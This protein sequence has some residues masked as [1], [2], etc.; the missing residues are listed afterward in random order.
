VFARQPVLTGVAVLTLSLGIGANAAMYSVLNAVLF[1]PLPFADAD[2]TVLVVERVRSGGGTS[3]TIPEI[4]D[5]RARSR[6]LDVV[7]FFDTRDAQIEGGAEPAHVS[8][9]RVDPAFLP[10]VGAR[11]AL[12]RL[13]TAEDSEA[14]SPRV[15]LLSDGLWRRNFGA[16][17]DVVGRTVLVN[18]ASHLIAGVL[19]PEFT[20][21]FLSGEPELYLPY[22]LVP[23]YTQRSGEFANVRRVETIGRVKPGVSLAAAS[24]DLASVS[25]GLVAEHP[26]LYANFG[27][28][29][30]FVIDVQPLREAVGEGGRRGLL[31]LF[32][33]V[34]LVLLIA[35]VNAAQFL[36]SHAIEREPEVALRNALGAGRARLV[37]QFLSETLLLAVAAG[38][39]GVAQ[40]LWLVRILRSQ[41]P[42]MLMVGR[43]DLDVRVL[44]FVAALAIGTT[45]V[46]GL[47]PSLRFSR[48]RL[49]PGLEARASTSP[50]SRARQVLIAIEVG[51]SVV[52]LVQAALLIRTLDVLQKSQAGFSSESVL[53]MRMRG[54]S[55]GGPSTGILYAQYL[56]RM[57]VV[58]DIAHAAIASSVLPGGAGTPYAIV[59]RS[60]TEAARSRQRTS[61][62]I[63]SPDYFAVLNIPFRQGR[64]FSP[65]ETA[66][67]MPVAVINEEMARLSWP[68]EDP[69]GQRLRA[70]E[71]PRDATLTVIGVVGNVTTV[72]QTGDVPQVYVS[73][74][75][76]SEPNMFILVRPMTGHTVSIE[77][78]KRAIWSVQPRQA[79]FN[80]L[81]LDEMLSQSVQG[82]RVVAMIL[83]SFATLAVAMSI[84][85]VFAVI[86]YLTTRRTKEVA[87]R[88]AIGARP[89]DVVQLLT[90]QTL[91]W[92]LIGLAAG[93][94]VAQLASRMLRATIPSV[95][96]L[97]VSMIVLATG[98]YLLVVGVATVLPA[99]RALRIDPASALRAE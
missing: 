94:G 32:G 1:R 60:E 61:Y 91:A 87:L 17:P 31:V 98:G 12:G 10:L 86:S 34:V 45:I 54:M 30:N 51:L 90:G 83:G 48:V 52:L 40:A 35:C 26:E 65:T 13:L 71:G 97:E 36:L 55:S 85:G 95:V 14:A 19:P 89:S 82:P 99:L 24:A 41:L 75:Q 22:P 63:V 18:G 4:L 84:A 64:T 33:A 5:L 11:P 49:R 9:A 76:Q 20:L 77:A 39:L 50:R 78:I 92:T 96:P 80:V 47:V 70:G 56:E 66:G 2:R 72:F 73:Y 62:Q 8:T 27:G 74:L 38:L 21:T 79:V 68:G 23:E 93:A 59:G 6:A 3:P 16:A 46:C 58:P 44:G 43:V 7:T 42:P 53:S 37:R 15:L 81:P 29:S 25:A 57:S 28:A 88:R 69:I 67:T